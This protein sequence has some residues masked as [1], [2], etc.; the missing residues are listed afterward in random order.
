MQSSMQPTS[1]GKVDVALE[2]WSQAPEWW[3]KKGDLQ[4]SSAVANGSQIL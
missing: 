4:K 3:S 1:R 2:W